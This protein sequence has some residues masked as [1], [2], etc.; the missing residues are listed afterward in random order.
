MPS[1]MPQHLIRHA[2]YHAEDR[3]T[4]LRPEGQT[5]SPVIAHPEPRTVHAVDAVK[6][7]AQA[8]QEAQS[9]ADAQTDP[10]DRKSHTQQD[11]HDQEGNEEGNDLESRR[12]HAESQECLMTRAT[13]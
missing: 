4:I 10:R 1:N 5:A 7:N 9:G 3:S 8:K 12:V 13:E 11:P 6:E 2:T